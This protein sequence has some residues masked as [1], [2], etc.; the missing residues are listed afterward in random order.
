[1][2]ENTIEV[3][4]HGQDKLS[5]QYSLMDGRLV[6]VKL[7]AV[8]C[9]DLLKLAQEWRPKLSGLISE[10]PPPPKANDHASLLLKELILRIKGQW[11]LPYQDHELCHCRSVETKKVL[12]AIYLG[13]HSA[14][15]VSK[16]T[17][18]GTSC[19]TCRPDIEALLSY[20]LK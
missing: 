19:G 3:L 2:T 5:L 18:A 4:I 6:N 14:S 7:S 11:F 10:L 15:D 8:G 20:V 16:L 13:A 12:D 9:L 17:T 1:M